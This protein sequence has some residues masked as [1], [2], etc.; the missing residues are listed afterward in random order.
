MAKVR[1]VATSWLIALDMSFRLVGR[2]SDKTG[3]RT[4]FADMARIN[5]PADVRQ[6]NA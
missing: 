4:I 2:N 1:R 5:N 6:R 3:K